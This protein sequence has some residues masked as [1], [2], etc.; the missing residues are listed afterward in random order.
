MWRR[1]KVKDWCAN[2]RRVWDAAVK[3][4]SALTAALRRS[5]VAEV[6]RKCGRLF[7]AIFWD[8]SKFFDTI[9]FAKMGNSA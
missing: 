2:V 5:V 4:R 8:L 1:F 3:G 9:E 6:A 7:A